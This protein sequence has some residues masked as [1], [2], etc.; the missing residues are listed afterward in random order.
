MRVLRKPLDL[1]EVQQVLRVTLEGY[2][3]DDEAESVDRAG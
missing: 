3:S 2:P 1:D